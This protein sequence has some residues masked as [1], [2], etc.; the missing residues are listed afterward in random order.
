MNIEIYNNT[1]QIAEAFAAIMQE[2]AKKT[3]K[4]A[5]HIALSGGS[6]PK[7]I[8]RELTEKYGSGLCNV[9][10]HFWWGDDRCVAPDHDDSNYKWANELWLQPIGIPKEN[11]HRVMGENKPEDETRR[12]AAEIE[13]YLPVENEH[14][15]FDIMLLG[16]GEDGHTAS[17]FPHQIGYISSPEIA[18]VATHPES[19]QKRISLSGPVI[20][21]SKNIIFLAT[22]EKKAAKVKEVIIDK[23]ETLPASHIKAENGQLTWWLDE[24]SSKLLK[25]L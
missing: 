17:I 14:P 11:I 21:N 20:N 4:E 9:R 18:V 23:N 22:G 12:Y 15:V 10:F 1:R 24:A 16:L 25:N 6:T 3:G 5:V 7:A 13:K 19:G 8:F 2:T